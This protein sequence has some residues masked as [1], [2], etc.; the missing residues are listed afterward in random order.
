MKFN[1]T[2]NGAQTVKVEASAMQVA[3]PFV[4]LWLKPE[5]S[6]LASKAAPSPEPVLVAIFHEPM[7]VVVE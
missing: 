3:G 6:V 1:V 7:A 2:T 4:S 5:K